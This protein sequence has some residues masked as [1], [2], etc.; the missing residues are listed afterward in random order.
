M[1]YL[2]TISIA[3]SFLIA[4]IFENQS[5]LVL[6]LI[7]AGFFLYWHL[8][9]YLSIQKERNFLKEENQY[10]I[11]S[12][13]SIR[14]PITLVHVPLRTICNDNCPENIK[15]DLS[16]AIRNIECLNENL[17]KLSGLK[18]LHNHPEV[19]N[20]TEH[21]LGNY[22][23]NRICSLQGYAT[24]KHIKLIIKTEFTYASVW[25]DKNK[26]SPIIDKFITNAIDCSEPESN[27]TLL[28][29]ISQEHWEISVPDSGNGKLTKLYNQNKHRMIRQKAEFECH[30]SKSILLKKLA[31]LCNGK[32]LVSNINHTVTLRFPV[33]CS[34]E[35]QSNHSPLC[36]TNHTEIEKIDRLLVKAPCKRNSHKPTIA[37]LK[38]EMS[39]LIKNNRFLR[40]SFLQRLF[41][42]EFLE[43]KA[44]EILQD[45]EHPLISKVTKIILENLDNEKLTIGSI[46]KELGISR[47]SLY[48]LSLIH[49]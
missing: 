3:A 22:L 6:L 27:I 33:K 34:C 47:T 21:E 10:F 46:A 11:D 42:E 29:S 20:I 13:Q 5:Y 15:N 39:I 37:D 9:H 18:Y 32:I 24:N 23:R 41:G 28:I 14:N 12:F 2:K 8:F 35:D 25:L 4:T 30:F 38:I 49:I 40:K 48:N 31:D 36:F 17:D 26:I 19:L 1:M 7:V 43:I 16:L 45:G 44:S